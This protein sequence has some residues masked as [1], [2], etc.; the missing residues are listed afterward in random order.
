MDTV[1][2]CPQSVSLFSICFSPWHGSVPLCW[3][4]DTTYAAKSVSILL[5]I[6]LSGCGYLVGKQSLIVPQKLMLYDIGFHNQFNGRQAIRN[7]LRTQ[8]GSVWHSKLPQVQLLSSPC[9]AGWGQ[10]LLLKSCSLHYCP[11]WRTRVKYSALA[12]CG[13]TFQS[14]PCSHTHISPC[15]LV[16]SP[17]R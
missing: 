3:R 9:P 16:C 17:C 4:V 2:N 7:S 13:R 12:D 1:H 8:K 11:L 10:P 15:C 6:F 14:V 5:A